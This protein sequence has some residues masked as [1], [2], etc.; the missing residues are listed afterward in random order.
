MSLATMIALADRHA[1]PL[2]GLRWHTPGTATKPKRKPSKPRARGRSYL[3]DVLAANGVTSTRRVVKVP[4]GPRDWLIDH[5]DPGRELR[6][7]EYKVW[8]AGGAEAHAAHLE[9]QRE[10]VKRG[11]ATR[12]RATPTRAT[13]DSAAE[14]EARAL[15]ASGRAV[16]AQGADR[17]AALHEGAHCLACVALNVGV[18]TAY[19]D[20]RGEG[21]VKH[22]VT[23]A[24]SSLRIAIAGAMG[25][26]YATRQ[27]TATDYISA[28]DEANISKALRTLDGF[29]KPWIQSRHYLAATQWASALVRDRRDD[30]E[31]LGYLISTHRTISGRAV[32]L[33]VG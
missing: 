27:G 31:R 14:R 11:A 15:R 25:E 2:P 7:S 29:R 4:D 17:A 18:R 32:K 8:L 6:P 12:T 20:A 26:V 24:A 9:R 19:I 10:G 28:T 23:D 30:L 21:E 1:L 5:P 33:A 3:N 22:T 16:F 13:S